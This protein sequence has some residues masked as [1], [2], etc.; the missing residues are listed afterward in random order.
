MALDVSQVTLCIVAVSEDKEARERIESVFSVFRTHAGFARNSSMVA[1]NTLETFSRGASRVFNAFA[2][3][4][5]SELSRWN[6]HRAGIRYPDEGPTLFDPDT[7]GSPGYEYQCTEIAERAKAAI[8]KRRA[9][10][11]AFVPGLKRL[12]C[13]SRN[14]GFAHMGVVLTMADDSRYVLD[15]WATLDC[16]NPLVY[17]FDDFDNDLKD[18]AREYK[19]FA[20]FS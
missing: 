4:G 5:N 14:A 12:G 20:G 3:L 19:E 18:A 1:G 11:P 13:Y 10:D 16:A 15:W 2:S 7:P 6:G 9:R 17:R 8:E